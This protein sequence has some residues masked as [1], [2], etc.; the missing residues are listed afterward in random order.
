MN[1][2]V[3][4]Q[5]A[6]WCVAILLILWIVADAFKVGA[7]FDEDFLLSSREGEE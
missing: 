3:V 7:Q 4:L 5:V 6:A 2:W 1:Y